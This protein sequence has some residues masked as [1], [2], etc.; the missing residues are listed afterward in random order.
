[1]VRDP[2][3]NDFAEEELLNTA[4][5][6]A[7]DRLAD[8]IVAEAKARTRVQVSGRL[9]GGW[10]RRYW[11]PGATRR[12]IRKERGFDGAGPYVNIMAGRLQGAIRGLGEP[13]R[14]LGIGGYGGSR[15]PDHSIYEATEAQRGKTVH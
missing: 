14:P 4:G 3:W 1:M 10:E 6:E 13:G 2:T 5:G 15:Q 12:S 8:D 7:C 9:P 11:R